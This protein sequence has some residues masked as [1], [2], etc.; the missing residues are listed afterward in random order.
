MV[1]KDVFD[2]LEGSQL[3]LSMFKEGVSSQL[4]FQ[5]VRV[6]SGSG[7]TKYGSIE[8]IKSSI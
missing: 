3:T 6:Y 1:S 2:V 5:I 8:A 7:L 4:Y